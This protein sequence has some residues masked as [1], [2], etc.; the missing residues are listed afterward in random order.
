MKKG[1]GRMWELA[2]IPAYIFIVWIVLSVLVAGMGMVTSIIW[3]IIGYVVFIGVFGYI[4]YIVKQSGE[5]TGYAAKTGAFIGVIGGLVAAV[6][7]IISFYYFPAIFTE[8]INKAVAQGAPADTIKT[9]VAI[10][11]YAGIVID[12]IIYALFG[13]ALSAIGSLLV[14]K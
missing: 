7:A 11:V 3:S 1:F 12:P 9:M 8:T 14:K 4:G 10:G 6:L 13:A 2:E 5:T